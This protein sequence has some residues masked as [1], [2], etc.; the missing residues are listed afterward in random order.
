VCEFVFWINYVV[1]IIIATT[2]LTVV[3]YAK[4]SILTILFE[5]S[6]IMIV[7]LLGTSESQSYHSKQ[8]VSENILLQV[9]VG[10]IM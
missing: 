7:S 9:Y 10:N 4:L 5:F 1:Y 3:L 6:I 8:L 2:R